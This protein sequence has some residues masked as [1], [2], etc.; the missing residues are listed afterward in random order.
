VAVVATTLGAALLVTTLA[1]SAAPSGAAPDTPRASNDDVRLAAMHDAPSTPTVPFLE[2]GF[3]AES[4]YDAERARVLATDSVGSHVIAIPR[5]EPGASS[6]AEQLCVV[7]TDASAPTRGAGG[8]GSVAEFNRA[9]IFV[10]LSR[11]P[12]ET[13]ETVGVVPD[14]VTSVAVHAPT[15]HTRPLDVTDSVVRFGTDDARSVTLIGDG[16]PVDRPIAR[17]LDE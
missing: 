3:L 7:V 12:A 11:G 2:Q 14:G 4:G 5:T 6:A 10:T 9:G 13:N 1:L 8:C 17:G 16:Q 15:G